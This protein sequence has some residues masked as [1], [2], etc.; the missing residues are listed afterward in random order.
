MLWEAS[1][2]EMSHGER[3]RERTKN[4]E[5]PNISV[6]MLNVGPPA[7][8]TTVDAT[9]VKLKPPSWVLPKFLMHKIVGKIKWLFYTSNLGAVC[10]TAIDKHYYHHFGHVE[11][12]PCKYKLKMVC[13]QSRQLILQTVNLYVIQPKCWRKPNTDQFMNSPLIM[14]LAKN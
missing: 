5:A 3:V 7:L 2:N 9:W 14:S 8:P 12:C 1:E 10:Y 4:T 11:L 6:K 13:W